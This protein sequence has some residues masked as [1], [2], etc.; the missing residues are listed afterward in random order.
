MQCHQKTFLTR[1]WAFTLKR[2][3]EPPYRRDQIWDWLY[4]K[5]RKASTR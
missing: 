3:G 2:V 4:R 5:Q 1:N